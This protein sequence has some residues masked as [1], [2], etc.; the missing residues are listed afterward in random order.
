M[1]LALTAI[2]LAAT[3]ALALQLEADPAHSSASFTVK[4]MVANTVHGQFGKLTSTASFDPQD[5][6]K[7]SVTASIDVASINTNNEKRDGHLKSAD[8]FDAQKCP[9]ITFKSTKAEK[10]GNDQLKVTGDLTLHCVTKP[11]TLE[12]TYSPNPIK[13]PFGTTVYPATATTKI[14]RSDYG[15]TWN[16]T[17]ETGGVLVSDDVNIELNLEYVLKPA[18]AKKEAAAETK[19]PK[20]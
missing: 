11:V 15:L 2:L 16:K 9:Q 10:A 19:A 13:S 7:S 4:H 20:K 6:S 5:P 1:K 14:K 17:L 18:E 8:F 12:A 3:P